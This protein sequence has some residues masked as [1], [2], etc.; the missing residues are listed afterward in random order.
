MNIYSFLKALLFQLF[1]TIIICSA[2]FYDSY[3]QNRS[4]PSSQQFRLGDRIVRIAEPGQLADTLNVWGDINSPG[5]YLVPKNTSLPK[6]LS[7]ALGPTNFRDRQTALDWSKVR[8]EVN[9]S[10][11]DPIEGYENINRFQFR[12]SEPIPAEMRTFNLKND[13]IVSVEVKRKPAFIDY[14]R[15]IAPVVSTVATSILLIQRLN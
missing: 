12:Y 2:S 7:Y 9:V 11:Y 8:V 4:I 1:I 6:L 14:V 15:V 3:G 10:S 13:Q 5:R